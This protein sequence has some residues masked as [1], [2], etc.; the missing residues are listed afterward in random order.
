[1]E[2]PKLCH[3]CNAPAEFECEVCEEYYCEKHSATYT[4]FNQIDYDCCC[5]CEEEM[6]LRE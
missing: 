6:K 3:I 5:C 4:Q 1:M 2:E